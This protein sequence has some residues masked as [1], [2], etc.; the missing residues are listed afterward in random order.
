MANEL[1]DR[2][3]QTGFA[4]F[5]PFGALRLLKVRPFTLIEL[6]FDPFGRLRN[7]VKLLSAQLGAGRIIR[8]RFTLIE[9]LVVIAIIAILAAMLLPALSSARE[10]G[11]RI[12]CLSNSKQILT[13][14]LIY[15][16]D[17]DEVIPN[18]DG[19]YIIYHYATNSYQRGANPWA[20]WENS[21]VSDEILICPSTPNAGNYGGNSNDDSGTTIGRWAY[22]GET[23]GYWY[24]VAAL[25]NRARTGTYIYG[26]GGYDR[27]YYEDNTANWTDAYG[28]RGLVRL[29]AIK[30]PEKY[31]LWFDRVGLVR[32]DGVSA[33]VYIQSSNHSRGVPAGG[34]VAYTDGSARWQR[35]GSAIW[36]PYRDNDGW[37]NYPSGA[38]CI[39]LD[40][41]SLLPTSPNAIYQRDDSIIDFYGTCNAY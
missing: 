29:K 26:G 28:G 23:W 31:A 38:Y 40:H 30:R 13:G 12:A 15:A 25:V 2:R 39:P 14:T 1:S 7:C 33:D 36:T 24:G 22:R 18:K 10:R 11:R 21:Y 5:E 4:L 6:P 20:L 27:Q 3:T 8:T 37:Y 32:H 17:H 34:N 35:V 16:D 41:P 19:D 9:L